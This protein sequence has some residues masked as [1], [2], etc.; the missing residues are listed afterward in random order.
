MAPEAPWMVQEPARLV[1]LWVA[2][3]R[4]DVEEGGMRVLLART[5]AD[6]NFGLTFL[7]HHLLSLLPAK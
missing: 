4:G 1:V 3:D 2:Q 5:E 6:S 7:Y